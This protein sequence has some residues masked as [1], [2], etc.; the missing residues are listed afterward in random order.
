MIVLP[1]L[2]TSL[3]HFSL[4][5]CVLFELGCEKVKRFNVLVRVW[6]R[7]EKFNNSFIVPG[8][9]IPTATSLYGGINPQFNHLPSLS[10]AEQ[11]ID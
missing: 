1:I 8:L 6:V 4:K 7:V 10:T 5:V 9:S 11:T 2:T 3:I